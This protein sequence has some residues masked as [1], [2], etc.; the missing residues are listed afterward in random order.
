MGSQKS[1]TIESLRNS[2]LRLQHP[3]TLADLVD[4]TLKRLESVSLPE[5][6]QVKSVKGV[7][8]LLCAIHTSKI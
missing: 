5:I 2:I 3:V 7:K 4:K 8:A 6:K 1:N